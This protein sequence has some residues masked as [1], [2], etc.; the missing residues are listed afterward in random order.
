MMLNIDVSATAFYK[1]KNNWKNNKILKSQ[2]IP[3]AA[4]IFETGAMPVP[5]KS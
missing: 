1:G 3:L 5:T 4:G 2:K